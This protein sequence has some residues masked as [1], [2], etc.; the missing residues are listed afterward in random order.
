VTD[1]DPE[2]RYRHGPFPL[3]EVATLLLAAGVDP[4][5]GRQSYA[6]E[7]LG[8]QTGTR[9]EPLWEAYLSGCVR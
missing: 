8:G 4:H 2:S 3:H 7:M 9:H 5:I 6:E 1:D